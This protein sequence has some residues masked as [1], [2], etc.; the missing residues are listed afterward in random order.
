LRPL[1]PTKGKDKPFPY[2][3][4]Q[5]PKSRRTSNGSFQTNGTGKLRLKFFKYSAS[6]E[7]TIQPDIVEN[8]TNHMSKPGFDLILGCNS[9]NELGIVLDFWTTEFT[10]DEISL[11]MRD[12][13]NLRSKSAANKAWV[14][15][16]SIY[17]STSKEPQSMLE[18]TKPLID[19]S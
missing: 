5:A 2:L 10:I 18:A 7:Y 19:L 13:K 11:P 12:I 15:N 16:N 3:T 8:D 9:M 4:R 14:M 6:R 17:Q 1:F